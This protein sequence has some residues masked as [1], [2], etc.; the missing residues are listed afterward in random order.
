MQKVK[1]KEAIRISH[2]A[3]ASRNT[4]HVFS[5]TAHQCFQY[6][7]LLKCGFSVFISTSFITSLPFLGS[8]EVGHHLKPS[9]SG[10]DQLWQ[11]QFTVCS[12]HVSCSTAEWSSHLWELGIPFFKSAPAITRSSNFHRRNKIAFIYFSW[13]LLCIRKGAQDPARVRGSASKDTALVIFPLL[14]CASAQCCSRTDLIKDSWMHFCK[15]TV[16]YVPSRDSPWRLLGTLDKDHWV[17]VWPFSFGLGHQQISLF[18][19]LMWGWLFGLL[20]LYSQMRKTPLRASS[21]LYRP[22]RCALVSSAFTRA[23]V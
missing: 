7:R 2:T 3:Q 23:L 8:F 14:W 5:S 9:S 20:P 22:I 11:E 10:R 1:K 4:S 13:I 12:R 16:L 15:H 6:L 17:T 21:L 19:L 18:K